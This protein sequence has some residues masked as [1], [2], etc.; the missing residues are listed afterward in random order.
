[1]PKV[2][3]STDCNEISELERMEGCV[4][5][6]EK[7]QMVEINLFTGFFNLNRL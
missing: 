4:T 1:M 5:M 7:R 2:S 3:T 6:D